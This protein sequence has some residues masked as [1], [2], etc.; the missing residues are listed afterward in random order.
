MGTKVSLPYVPDWTRDTLF[1]DVDT[2]LASFFERP[3]ITR[4]YTWTPLQVGAFTAI[5][6]P[7]T[8]FF[9]NPRVINRINNYNL[10]RS[11]LH[12]RF[13]INGNGF[14]YGRLMADYLPL[15]TNDNVTSA[16]TIIAENAI[17]ASQR[18]KVFID[19]STCCSN[20][21]ELPFV[22]YRDGVSIP[23]AEWS[24]LGSIYVREL[25]G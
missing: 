10:L 12:V 5:F 13:L 20:E 9:G 19:P 18:M 2:S 17:Q 4:T 8:D 24:E 22:Y 7:W 1:K 16:A 11:K 21:L 23:S 25:Q 14:Y 3:I 6:N 15:P